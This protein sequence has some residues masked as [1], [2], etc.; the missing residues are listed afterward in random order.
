M[1]QYTRAFAEEMGERF[2]RDG[3]VVIDDFL[4]SANLALLNREIDNHFAPLLAQAQ[5][6][7][8]EQAPEK[9]QFEC[10]VIAWN[11]CA[12]GN[13]TFL[14]LKAM[15]KLEEVT[16]AC[17]GD[18]FGAPDSL[19]MLATAG[20]QGQAWHQDCATQESGQFNLNR[21]FY[22]RDVTLEDGAIVVVPGSHRSGRIP[23]GGNQEPIAGEITLTPKAGTLVLL[24]GRVFHR[25]T[26]NLS[27]KERV[28]V[29]FRAFPRNVLPDVCRIGVYRNGAYDFVADQPIQ[30]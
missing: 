24:H 10:D 25:V 27:G 29:N 9:R 14:D 18:G 2:Q 4:A 21:L 17:L 20:G 1:E 28:S 13:A 3:I 8:D 12:E 16:R 23:A 19:V 15:P 6:M 22:T 5:R 30:A 7:L 11:P 26:P